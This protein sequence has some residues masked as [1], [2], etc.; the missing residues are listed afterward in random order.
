MQLNTRSLVEGSYEID[1]FVTVFPHIGAPHKH[2]AVKTRRYDS[3]KL[4]ALFCDYGWTVLRDLPYGPTKM[5]SVL[6][7]E[8]RARR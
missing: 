7:M 1:F 3:D 6:V 5:S 8:K 2:L 4:R